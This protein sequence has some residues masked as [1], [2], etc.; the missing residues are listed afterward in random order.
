M[1]LEWIVPMALFGAFVSSSGASWMRRQRRLDD[2]RER[3]QRRGWVFPVKVR[4]TFPMD[5]RGEAVVD[6]A[7]DERVGLGVIIERA[8]ELGYERTV[9]TGVALAF[10]RGS[11]WRALSSFDLCDVPSELVVFV[12]PSPAAGI[13]RLRCV[14]TFRTAAHY[15]DDADAEQATDEFT[16]L[17]ESLSPIRAIPTT[18]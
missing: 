11:E 17:I 14:M 4:S 18:P 12:E 5:I 7:F 15:V 10:R 16:T 3:G 1:A 9:G 6:T 13:T 8:L 2:G